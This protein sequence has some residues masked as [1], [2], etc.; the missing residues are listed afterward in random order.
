M[1]HLTPK[2][3]ALS[4]SGS[5][6]GG[7]RRLLLISLLIAGV[8]G[9]WIFVSGQRSRSDSPDRMIRELVAS[10]EL[11]LEL[12]SQLRL[13]STGVKNLQLPAPA[14][15]PKLFSE[16]VEVV[17]LGND[18]RGGI[19]GD[20]EL[21]ARMELPMAAAP[22]GVPRDELALWSSLLASVDYFEHAAFKFVRAEFVG[23]R[24]DVFEGLVKFSGLARSR[25]GTWAGLSGE[26]AVTWH[27]G[28][29][30]DWRIS[31]WEMKGMKATASPRRLFSDR[32]D[33][34][35][36]DAA[37]RKR[38]RH[39]VHEEELVKYYHS[40]KRR[41]RSHDFAPIAMNQKP[42]ISV[43][44]LDGDGFDDVY[45]MVRMGKN[46][47]LRNR[48]DGTFEERA[49]ASELALGGNSTCGIFADF[50]N[51]GD[52]DLILGRSVERCQYFE[53]TGLWF[54]EVK[55]GWAAA[56]PSLAM[57][58]SAAD[59]NGDGL[60][61]FYIS[62]YRPEAL[63]DGEAG[64]TGGSGN[65]GKTWPGRFLSAQDAAASTTGGT[66]RPTTTSS[67]RS[68]HRTR[69]GSTGAA[70]DSS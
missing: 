49:A 60:L 13:L 53:N 41:A 40:G 48:G 37:D 4:P 55:E 35:L 21:G 66:G 54:S 23:D 19:H 5:G 28:A 65:T 12:G 9:I 11:I 34:S 57:S 18:D 59:F 52:P 69:F 46:L 61:D 6:S 26:Q 8:A 25:T 43:V 22:V 67:I 24:H 63:G 16:V 29:D 38:A 70:D 27:Q 1:D 36:P 51:D 15:V 64:L 33:E 68:G 20:E 58:I 39:S 56:L 42:A 7:S 2:E 31:S 10:E 50:D 47:L 30:G 44:D 3:N 14:D 45:V 32:L 62:T 17:A